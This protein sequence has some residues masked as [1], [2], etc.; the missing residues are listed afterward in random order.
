[1]SLRSLIKG[2]TINRVYDYFRGPADELKSQHPP[3]PA[4]KL[5]RESRP[6]Q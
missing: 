4:E 3:E 1:M 2:E 6:A 5:L